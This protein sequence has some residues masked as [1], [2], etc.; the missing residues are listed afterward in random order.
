VPEIAAGS[1]LASIAGFVTGDGMG[2]VVVVIHR[3]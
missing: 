3:A 1:G 2:G